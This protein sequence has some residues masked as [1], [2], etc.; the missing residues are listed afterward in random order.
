[1]TFIS[2]FNKSKG[3][4]NQKQFY[5]IL[6]I[7]LIS[8]S[9]L[10]VWANHLPNAYQLGNDL[11]IVGFGSSPSLLN[12][13]IAGPK[14]NISG[15]YNLT[16]VLNTSNYSLEHT[17]NVSIMFYSKNFSFQPAGVYNFTITNVSG[18][19]CSGAN[20]GAG[21]GWNC[22]NRSWWNRSLNTRTIADGLY[23]LTVTINNE[24]DSILVNDT[25]AFNITI[26]NT[27]PNITSLR[28][29][30]SNASGYTS[31]FTRGGVI[32]I[33]ATVNDTTTY[34]TNVT[35]G[36]RSTNT[37]NTEFNLTTNRTDWVWFTDL[38]LSTVSDG[39]YYVFVYA[40]DTLNNFNGSNANFTAFVVD[41]TAPNITYLRVN[42]S[43]ASG[44]TSNFTRGGV[45]R[46]NATV[47]D[48]T[49]YVR[50]VTF[51]VRT[52][53]G[54]LNNLTEFNVTTNRTD[55][56]WFA[57]VPLNTFSDGLYYV[58]VYA[59]DT[60]NN[61]NGS[62]ANFTAFVVDQTAP[63]ITALIVGNLTN[64]I[65]LSK[66][67]TNALA[68]YIIPLNVSA[69]DTTTYVQTL[70]FNV[71]NSSGLVNNLNGSR[72][73]TK[74]NASQLLN[75]SLLGDGF[76]TV[77]VIANDSLGNKNN[78]V[79]FT[80]RIDRVPPAV[81][82]SCEGPYTAG[83]TVTC[84]CTATDT[85]GSLVQT[86]PRFSNG[87]STESTTATGTGGTSSGCEAID[88]AGNVRT[89]ITSTWTV[90]AT[91]SG[92]GG[93]GG[94]GGGSSS[95]VPGQIKKE[96]WTS[97]NA[98]ETATVEV[99]N[100]AICVTEV[101]FSVA[102]TTYGAWVQVKKLDSLPSSVEAFDNTKY[103]SLEITE[104]NI[105]SALS[106]TAT[107]K[108]KVENAWLS[109]NSVSAANVALFR[110]VGSD[111][112]VLPTTMGEDDGT[113]VYYSATTPGFSYFVIGEAKTT[114]A[115]VAA[116]ETAPVE[117]AVA[118]EA[119]VEETAE[120]PAVVSTTSNAVVWI[121]PLVV[122]L[123]VAGLLYWYWQRR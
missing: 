116:E 81:T 33:N 114:A 48:T 66:N 39:I 18:E 15:T 34:V 107:V 72:N 6:V 84:T 64:G 103:R 98:G 2:I 67:L 119:D 9:A 49:T 63:N 68:N 69:N 115:P 17:T 25:L 4:K 91:S 83:Q 26:D 79:N 104:R 105:E 111:W 101:S 118:E 59:N 28:V 31:N 38:A 87:Q 20:L 42:V 8:L 108:F 86:G 12:S 93:A 57:D 27:A 35:F 29:N 1:M 44:Y 60:L 32:R 54:S 19:G 106:G 117:E 122:L 5:S 61:F 90:T 10:M 94:S 53:G 36:I 121:V 80:F 37:T 92:G 46:F 23:N 100:R 58:F 51:G 120:A 123:L 88:Y 62:N 16:L 112:T 76:Y 71:S 65:N 22:T 55:W 77:Q 43:N 56:V 89:G 40:N 47:N 24:T 82:V 102:T 14:I 75:L 52:I 21:A 99:A 50:N 78:S 41:Q 70:I 30:V 11:G 97:I 7:L 109:E 85:L 45:L 73:N 3:I 110:Y 74:W 96:V 95:V 113:Y 13:V